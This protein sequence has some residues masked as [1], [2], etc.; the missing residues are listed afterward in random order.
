MNVVDGVGRV[1]YL[2]EIVLLAGDDVFE[3]LDLA[4]ELH[5]FDLQFLSAVFFLFESR[6][7]RGDENERRD[8]LHTVR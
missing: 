1:R 4:F 5:A 6:N 3:I 2:G 7:A 8:R